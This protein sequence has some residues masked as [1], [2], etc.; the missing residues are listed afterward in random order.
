MRPCHLNVSSSVRKAEP[1]A[2]RAVVPGAGVEAVAVGVG[3]GH[4][5]GDGE[6]DKKD[7]RSAIDRR[8]TK[9]SPMARFLDG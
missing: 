8:K 3:V 6:H 1:G 7:E 4:R 9:E 2:T 5:A